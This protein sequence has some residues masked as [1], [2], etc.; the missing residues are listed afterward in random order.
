M[1]HFAEQSLG[2]PSF[3][4]TGAEFVKTRE[5]VNKE[6]KA[7]FRISLELIPI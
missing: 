3:N 1:H 6:I 7:F 2:L 4:R 5:E